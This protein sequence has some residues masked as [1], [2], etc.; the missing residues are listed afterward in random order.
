MMPDKLQ[1]TAKE[2]YLVSTKQLL[3]EL[4][5]NIKKVGTKMELAKWKQ[6][7]WHKMVIFSKNVG[8]NF[9]ILAQVDATSGGN[10]HLKSQANPFSSFWDHSEEISLWKT[11]YA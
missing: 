6:T 8:W 9:T 7:L 4:I 3:W 2:L 11:P 5:R 10:V 1:I